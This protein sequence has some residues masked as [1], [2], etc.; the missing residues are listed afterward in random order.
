MGRRKQQYGGTKISILDNT[1][2]PQ[3]W[4]PTIDPAIISQGIITNLES[5]KTIAAYSTC[6]M[7]LLGVLNPNSPI[8]IR[9]QIEDD[10]GQRFPLE[11]RVNRLENVERGKIYTNVVMKI[12]IVTS[13]VEKVK[14][15]EM[16]KVTTTKPEITREVKTQHTVA[17][18]MLCGQTASDIIPDIF[19]ECYLTHEQFTSQIT[20]QP[21][22]DETR[23]VV[24]WIKETA[25]RPECMIH[26]A[27]MNYVDGYFTF[28]EFYEKNQRSPP[29]LPLSLPHS[30]HPPSSGSERQVDNLEVQL[31][32]LYQAVA[33]IL[34]LLLKGKIMSYD[35]HHRNLLT[36]GSTVMCL[37]LGRVYDFSEDRP[38]RD[39]IGF[40][41]MCMFFNGTLGI[42]HFFDVTSKKVVSSKFEG[43]FNGLLKKTDDEVYGFLGLTLQ[44]KRKFVYKTLIFLAF[45][46]G[47]T[48]MNNYPKMQPNTIQFSHVLKR[49]FHNINGEA[50]F[51]N[52]RTFLETFTIEYDRLNR[53]L[54]ADMDIA[55]DEISRC[56]AVMLGA[57]PQQQRYQPSYF[58]LTTITETVPEPDTKSVSVSDPTSVFSST[59]TSTPVHSHL[60]GD[61]FYDF[62]GTKRR[63]CSSKKK[64]KHKIRTQRRRKSKR[65]H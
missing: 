47:I 3:R 42:N 56:L 60:P 55:L 59:S 65:R 11:E 2:Q 44:E 35:F 45:I 38:K 41:D 22:D 27:F 26:I 16:V 23:E 9:S 58:D 21:T 34:T 43:Y 17:L 8:R 40:I 37:D 53:E 18:R 50:V 57:C 36:N 33:V 24:E 10:S 4:I 54:A 51:T 61:P 13:E 5:V 12:S 14:W 62:G 1:T 29:P 7:V 46:D 64:R 25:K 19:S 39:L 31:P 52:F 32:V 30:S 15:Q 20:V 28:K 63:R 48:N 49:V 6:S